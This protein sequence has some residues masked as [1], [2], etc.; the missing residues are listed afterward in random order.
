MMRAAEDRGAEL[1]F[2]ERTWKAADSERTAAYIDACGMAEDAV[3]RYLRGRGAVTVCDAGCGCGV[4]A[5]KLLSFGF[6]VAGFDISEDAVVLAKSLL[7][8]KGCPA[9]G[10]R[11]ADIAATGYPDGAFDAVVARDVIDHMLIRDGV[12]A[13]RELMRIM[14][15]GGC[16]LLTLDMTDEEYEAEPHEVSADGDYIYT[17]GQWRGMVFH[18][19]SP[20]EI[21]V[22][23]RG[24][25]AVVLESAGGS[26]TVAVEKR[27]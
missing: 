18:P 19:Y 23:T 17:G 9:D 6:D 20:D 10:F 16:V 2:W 14:R 27:L 5:L 15:P 22:L 21:A 26:F 11:A 1:P 7:A 13:L 12:A 24:L 25:G 4:Y 3:I 8:A